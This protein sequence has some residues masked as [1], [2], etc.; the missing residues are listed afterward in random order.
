MGAWN[1]ARNYIQWSLDYIKAENREVE[2]IGRE[3]AASPASGYL[4]KHL[5]QQKEILDKVLS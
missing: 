5:A 4:H 1:S 3:P 2:Y